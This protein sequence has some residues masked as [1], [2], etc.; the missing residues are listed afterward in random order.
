LLEE[1]WSYLPDGYISA[2]RSPDR[3]PTL[4]IPGMA[5]PRPKVPRSKKL[6]Q[7]RTEAVRVGFKFCYQQKDYP[8]ILAVADMLPET[9]LNEDE[10]LQMLYDNAALRA[11]ATP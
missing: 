11:E 1:F 10:Q 8:T 4:P 5:S 2:S 6:K 3:N 9:V 7:V